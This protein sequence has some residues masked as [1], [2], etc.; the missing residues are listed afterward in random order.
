MQVI[1]LEHTKFASRGKN[2]HIPNIYCRILENNSGF[3]ELFWRS[4]L[5]YY[6][7]LLYFNLIILIL[8]QQTIISMMI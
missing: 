3:I 8:I 4:I 7:R 6:K 1:I 5:P 2:L